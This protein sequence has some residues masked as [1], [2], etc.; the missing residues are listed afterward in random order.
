M[1]ISIINNLIKYLLLLLVIFF[2]FFRF[3]ELN[4]PDIIEDED[5][6]VRDAVG[7]YYHDP[8]V[9][10]RH[11]TFRHTVG[12]MGHPFFHHL[13]IYLSYKTFNLSYTSSRLPA[14]LMSVFSAVVTYFL[15]KKMFDEKTAR[16]AFIL[17][18]L[19]PL[20][21]RIARTAN[22]DN[23]FASMGGVSIYFFYSY[24][25]ERKL[26]F[27]LGTGFFSAL[28]LSSKINGGIIFAVFILVLGI[29]TARKSVSINRR[30]IF[31]ALGGLTL[32]FI[33]FF[34]FND[35][36]S[37]IDAIIH[38]S[39]RR[40]VSVFTQP[41]AYDWVR[42]KGAIIYLFPWHFSLVLFGST[43]LGLFSI[44][45]NKK[46]SIE[47]TLL[48]VSMLLFFTGFRFS[49]ERGLLLSLIPASIITGHA[50]SKYLFPPSTIKSILFLVYILL[51][52]PY[53]LWYGF[54]T[55]PLPFAPYDHVTRFYSNRLSMFE[56]L[57][58]LPNKNIVVS[59]FPSTL[60]F[61]G[62]NVHKNIE[63]VPI[64]FKDPQTTDYFL[65]DSRVVYEEKLHDPQFKLV[66][67]SVYKNDMASLFKRIK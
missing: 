33:I 44:W 51:F 2:L 41:F 37:Y 1:K 58:Q 29:L 12:T 62:M 8:Y 65:T 50:I 28:L 53:L 9:N 32:C 52:I 39:D 45:K 47:Y 60:F 19:S 36:Y 59:V 20:V 16:L 56:Y 66:K 25:R 40:Y 35:P 10:P 61:P 49:L 46:Y 17:Y 43:I 13:L 5:G 67:M 57:N 3:Y 15:A 4:K 64:A 11:H 54:R 14:A 34:L 7:Y 18:I 30:D 6:H 27:A 23:T 31:F 22:I 26:Y 38:P 55:K 42:L 63:L 48:I 24:L 21:F